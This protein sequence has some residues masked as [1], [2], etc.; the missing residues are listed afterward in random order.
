MTH[1]HKN[2]QP[3]VAYFITSIAGLGFGI[4]GVLR[5]A[6]T[7]ISEISVIA[8]TIGVG[9]LAYSAYLYG[10][11]SESQIRLLSSSSHLESSR[12]SPFQ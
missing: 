7:G 2:N 12:E 1:S 3:L 10:R 4:N 6:P 5:G 8:C 11:L 9:L